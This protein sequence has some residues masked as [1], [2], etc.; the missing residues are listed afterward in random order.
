M[1]TK[2]SSKK[3]AILMATY[4][5]ERYLSEQ[6]ESIIG[7][8]YQNWLLYIKDDQSTDKTLSIVRKYV[9]L[10]ERI[11]LLEN[12]SKY[13]AKRNFASMMQEV[14]ADFYMFSDQDDIWFPEKVERSISVLVDL[15]NKNPRKP[16]IVHTD[17][18]VVDS[19]LSMICP[20]LW[21]M[22]RIAPELLNNFDRLGGHCLV[23][24]CT[25]AFNKKAQEVSLPMEEN[26]IMHDVWM[27][28]KVYQNEGLIVGLSQPSIYY[29]QHNNN[30][31]GAKD[32]RTHYVLNKLKRLR[33]VMNE[34]INYYRMLKALSYGSVFKFIYYKIW[35]Y[36]AYSRIK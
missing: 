19:N 3:L 23:T 30:T 8:T 27:A 16:I 36:I 35:Y 26:A 15:E 14:D 2:S 6:I 12:H 5:G 22:F 34:N 1:S 18:N 17:L 28:L 4:N 10:D 13:G 29:R 25:M 24:G 21:Q 20:S 32:F 11:I 33:G 7:Q 9:S 31:L